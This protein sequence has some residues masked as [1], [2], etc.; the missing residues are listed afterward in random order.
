M[1]CK[2]C[3]TGGCGTGGLNGKT[4][5]CQNNGACS[6]GGCNKMNVFDWLSDMD[7]PV[8]KRFDVVEVKFKGGRKE[9]FRNINQLELHTGDYVVCEMASGYHI[10]AVSLQG[11]LVRL[12]MVKKKV[13]ND[14]NLKSIYRV[15]NQRDL[16]KHEQSI[17]RDLTTMYRARE[18][19]KE[20]KINMKL[21]DVEFQSDN[22][23]ATFYYSAD[24]RVDFRELIKVLAG[25]FKARIEMRQISLRQEAGRL[26][27]LGACGRELCCSTWLTDFKNITTSAARY[28]NLSLNPTKLSG[29]CGRLKCCLN[30]ELE[31][32]IDA[33]KDIPH[34]DAP[35]QTQ[36]GKA[37]L[38]KTDIFKK[39]MWFGY[40]NDSTTWHPITLDQVNEILKMNAKG[41]KPVSLDVLEIQEAVL[42]LPFAGI[43]SD[44]TKMDK[45]FSSRDQQ[46]N[47]NNSNNRKNKKKKSGGGGNPAANPTTSPKATAPNKP[48]NQPPK[49][50]GE[51]K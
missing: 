3:S 28:Q 43:N 25:E 18:M 45:K 31:T 30:Y 39:I 44:L 17:A 8:M 22:T 29:Q 27:G 38:Q 24:E 36:K 32:Y 9:Y 7:V 13:A 20:L 16:E 42:A 15:A 40:E 2:S 12:Q 10:G 46:N 4:A 23:K 47:G 14:E 19:V 41:E 21:S 11:D 49:G 5:G 51:K 50:G 37:H 6:T 1:G 34:V 48:A 26:G 33:L 35:L